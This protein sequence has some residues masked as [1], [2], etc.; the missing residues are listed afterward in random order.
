MGQEGLVRFV[1]GTDGAGVTTFWQEHQVGGPYTTLQESEAALAE[2]ERLYPFVYGL[3]P[4]KQPG[5][6]VLDYGCGPGHDTLLFL[7]NDAEFVYYADISRLALQITHDRIRLHGFNTE[8]AVAFTADNQWLPRVDHVHCAGVIHHTEDPLAELV[9]LRMALK[10]DGEARV[11]VYDGELSKHT[12]S[13]VP[14]TE[15]WT[16][17]EF[18]DLCCDAGFDG[19][20][21]GS[22]PCPAEWRPDCYAA[23]FKLT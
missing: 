20:H 9:K 3:M 10:E 22:Y 23:C 2:R 17:D 16:P 5:K 11:M 1:R 8:N 12:Q 4:V 13:E 15:W 21:M 14:I 7:Q 6:V 18:L 19:R